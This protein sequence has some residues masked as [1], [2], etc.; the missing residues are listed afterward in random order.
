MT[1]AIVEA[2]GKQLWVEAGRFYDIDR[3]A[4]EPD[5]SITFD[6]VLMLSNNGSTEV[7]QPHVKGATVEATVMSHL[8]GKKVIV[9][10]MV[11][12]KKTRKKQGHRQELTRVMVESI[13]L[14]GKVLAQGEAAAELPLS[15]AE[16]EA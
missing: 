8:R 1:Y 3:Q 15:E 10:K 16:V 13:S 11:P 2:A 5:G 12:K 4:V 9:Y 7:G 14:N 6:K